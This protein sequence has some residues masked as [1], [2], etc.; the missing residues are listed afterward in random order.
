MGEASNRRETM[1][2]NGGAQTRLNDDVCGFLIVQWNSFEISTHANMNVAA[3][4]CTQ[5]LPFP[6]EL[7]S[8]SSAT[9]LAVCKKI[10][11]SLISQ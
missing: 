8:R 10:Y 4:V 7:P 9:V 3:E 2:S 1:M 6:N 11:S 5:N